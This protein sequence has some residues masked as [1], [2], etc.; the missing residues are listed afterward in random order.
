MARI[1][2]LLKV[3]KK[4]KIRLSCV[5]VKKDKKDTDRAKTIVKE[6]GLPFFIDAV[7]SHNEEMITAVTYAV[8]C[9]IDSL[10]RYDLV[11]RWK[12]K[13]KIEEFSNP[14][15]MDQGLESKVR[16]I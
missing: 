12:D 16:S 9:I 7:S 10:S 15:F 6:A 13:D 5:R 14:K 1:V 11:K 8:Q 4:C 2:R 3:E